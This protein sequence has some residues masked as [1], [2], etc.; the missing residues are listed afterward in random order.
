MKREALFILNHPDNSEPSLADR[1]QIREMLD[2]V[3]EFQEDHQMTEA[4]AEALRDMSRKNEPKFPLRP[5]PRKN[6]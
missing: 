2:A 3:A 1:R 5:C 4:E 6:P